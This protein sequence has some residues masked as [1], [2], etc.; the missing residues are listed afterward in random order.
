MAPQCA[1][2]LKPATAVPF[3]NELLAK[4]YEVVA[5]DYEGEGTPG[6]LPYLVGTLAARNTIDMV[7]AAHNLA[8]AH[9]STKYAVWG[10]SEGGQTAMFALHIAKHYAPTLHI[11]GVVAGAP[12]SQFQ[13]VYTFLK[14]GPYRYYLFMAAEGFNAGYG[15]RAAPLGEVMNEK[16]MKL[17]PILEN[18]CVTYLQTTLDRYKIQGMVKGDPFDN[19]KWK[20]LIE[21]NDPANFKTSTSIPLLIPQGGNDTQI[22]VAST[23]LL[24]SDMCAIGQ[25]TERWIYPGQT[26]SGVIRYYMG[27]MIHW[28]TDRF[29]YD[30]YP[31]PYKPVGLPGVTVTS[32]S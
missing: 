19:P 31:D 18:G 26:H 4:G 24:F 16:A 14:T 6:P 32:C 3:Q 20:K 10:H 25:K 11:V 2:S 5:S 12:P 21:E 7:R 15:N 30:P 23:K 1:P 9:S 17:L 22:P 27:D 29:S 8:V 13:Y 28:L